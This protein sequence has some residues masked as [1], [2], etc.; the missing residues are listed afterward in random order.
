[1]ANANISYIQ[2]ANTFDDWRIATNNLAN[3]ANQL[4][5][6]LYYKDAGGMTFGP[7]ASPLT[8][9]CT[10]GTVLIVGA[11]ASVAN[12]LTAGYIHDTGDILVDGYNAIF[13]N[14]S[15][16]MQVA[17]TAQTKNL[18]SNVQIWGQNVNA[19][20]YVVFTGAN[21]TGAP[22]SALL[23]ANVILNIA[24]N[25][26][27]ANTGTMNIANTAY[28]TK[29]TGN[30]VNVASNTYTGNLMVGLSTGIGANANVFGSI[31]ATSTLEV[32]ANANLYS[33]LTV[34]ANATIGGKA[35]VYGTANVVGTLET[36]GNTYLYSNLA[37]SKNTTISQNANVSGTIN[38]L[39][40]LEATGNAYLYSN[41]AVSKNTTISQNANVFGTMGV[42]GN[43]FLQSNLF[44]SSNATVSQNVNVSGT[45]NVTSVT[46]LMANANL[47][48]NLT[49][50]WNTATG[51]ASVVQNTSTG[52]LTV[53]QNTSSGNLAVTQNTSTGNLVVSTL[54]NIATG[55]IVTANVATL[56]VNAVG[57]LLY[58]NVEYVQN[59]YVQNS[60]TT[61]AVISYANVY[62]QANIFSANILTANIN[63][64]NVNY[65]NVS[66]QAALYGPILF[67]S[68]TI[69]AA[70]TNQGSA[71]LISADNTYIGS[72]TGGVILPA[73]VL[74]R[75]ISI[76]NST[77][78]PINLYPASGNSLENLTANA[79]VVVPG[80]ATVSVV[81]KSGSNW[82]FQT[83]V[84]NPGTGVYITQAASGTVTFAIGQPVLTTN[85]VTFA[86]VT[87]TQNT[88]TGNLATTQNTSTGNLAV[89]QNTTLGNLVVT[90]NTSTGNLSITTL[91]SIANSNTTN[92]NAVAFSATAE[93]GRAH[94]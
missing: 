3:G 58:A 51:N 27:V 36:T 65:I 42:A 89:T 64:E 33:G 68:A 25:I 78:S 30:G 70:G 74:G 50:S 55:N 53:S 4:R 81:A 54:A 12:A 10:S 57:A 73:A 79:P 91:A 22:S 34:S 29:P 85:S 11:D 18:I 92:A 44:V 5:N 90:Q 17:N 60:N 94:V 80:Y 76:T 75:E 69:A 83:P 43:T 8:L 46:D 40:T 13:D 32:S 86:N 87:V 66:S 37:V 16:L 41:L 71:T 28:F 23:G 45:M 1:M 39:S 49:V 93:I 63:V 67:G 9:A 14:P 6:S 84:Y 82:W 62:T 77:S 21:T 72:G 38:I 47:H 15:V 59:A 20:G 7:G 35:N 26:T 31:N 2:Q 19:N 61:N 52:N 88:S 24:G 56:N 48:S